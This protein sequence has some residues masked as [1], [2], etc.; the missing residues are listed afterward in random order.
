MENFFLTQYILGI[1]NP[2]LAIAAIIYGITIFCSFLW[3]TYKNFG[4]LQSI[5][6]SYYVWSPWQN[7]MIFQLFMYISAFSI[8]C[9]LQTWWYLIVG[10]LFALMTLFPSVLYKDFI[11]PHCAF[12]ISAITL[13]LIGLPL[14]FGSMM[15]VL[16]TACF[17]TDTL[18]LLF[19]KQKPAINFN[20]GCKTTSTYWVEVISIGSFL[21]GGIIGTIMILK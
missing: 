6:I 14:H 15:I 19:N 1:Y 2:I 5:S 10:V 13:A 4:I 9:I 8:V 3:F 11:K 7:R 20:D 18:V 21:I 17:V 16:L 12:A